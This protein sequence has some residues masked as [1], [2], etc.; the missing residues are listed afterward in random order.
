MNVFKDSLTLSA[1]VALPPLTGNGGPNGVRVGIPG[2]VYTDRE[3][4][5]VWLCNN[6]VGRW[7]PV[8]TADDVTVIQTNGGANTPDGVVATG[9][10]LWYGADLSVWLKSNKTFDDIGWSK[11]SRGT[12]GGA[13]FVENGDPLL[14]ELE[15]YGTDYGS[16]PFGLSAS[17]FVSGTGTRLNWTFP[18]TFTDGAHAVPGDPGAGCVSGNPIWPA[19]A[20]FLL[21]SS[22]QTNPPYEPLIFNHDDTDTQ[23]PAPNLPGWTVIQYWGRQFIDQLPNTTLDNSVDA[24]P[25]KSPTGTWYYCLIMPIGPFCINTGSSYTVTWNV[26]QSSFKSS[27]G[28][29]GTANYLFGFNSTNKNLSRPQCVC[30]DANGKIYMAGAIGPNQTVTLGS[31]SATSGGAAQQTWLGIVGPDG[32]PILLR[33]YNT[34]GGTTSRMTPYGIAVNSLGNIVVCGNQSFSANPGLGAMANSGPFIVQYSST[35]VPMWQYG[36]YPQGTNSNGTISNAVRVKFDGS[37]NI[38]CAGA[39]FGNYMDFGGGIR[40]ASNGSGVST[41]VLRLSSTGTHLASRGIDSDLDCHLYDMTLTPDNGIAIVGAF[42][43]RIDPAA[44]GGFPVNPASPTALGNS[45]ST[46]GYLVKLNN[47][48]SFTYIWGNAYSPGYP[49]IGKTLAV[50]VS[51][52]GNLYTVWMNNATMTV[53]GLGDTPNFGTSYMLSLIKHT[54]AGVPT[55]L[56]SFLT[57]GGE[58]GGQ[59]D[60]P[61]VY[62]QCDPSGNPVLSTYWSHDCDWGSGIISA[63]F[64]PAGSGGFPAFF[65]STIIGKYEAASSGLQPSNLMW[66][67]RID[68]TL[69]SVKP[70]GACVSQNNSVVTGEFA[71]ATAISGVT[72]WAG[73]LALAG[74]PAG[75]FV[76][77]VGY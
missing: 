16:V 65:Y 58:N 43:G 9:P 64:Q 66:I 44:A 39:W 4:Q 57:N 35:G 61:V 15:I 67:D 22:T 50:S 49:A 19:K 68:G 45:N 21:R 48:S 36:T 77:G 31:L 60:P 23:A 69:A 18:S 70:T 54:S 73:N 1:G 7:F 27:G 32:T 17:A 74:S 47:D 63:N 11:I 53:T 14:P 3:T 6:Q 12:S 29:N 41:F 10:A 59:S 71:D 34:S 55:M 25:K 8:G 40:Y 52:D 26:V 46:F 75:I 30:S 24:D 56:K 42:N 5:I 72:P 13:Y 62:L 38:V 33:V 20:L 51:P 2:E 76:A 28:S 37:G